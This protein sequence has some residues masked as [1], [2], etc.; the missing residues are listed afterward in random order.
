MK[1]LIILICMF[2]ANTSYAQVNRMRVDVTTEMLQDG[3]IDSDRYF[4]FNFNY[5]ELESQNFETLCDVISVTVNNKNCSNPEMSGNKAL[6]LKPEY[7][8]ANYNGAENFICKYRKISSENAELVITIKSFDYQII[9]RII[10]NIKSNSLVDYK[11]Q[12]S[13][14]SSITNKLE[15]VEYK[16]IKAKSSF[17]AGWE[18]V[19]LGCN[20]LAIPVLPKK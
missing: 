5:L 1:I 4:I 3:K 6:W 16:P 12:M 20:K 18:T 10:A 14:T 17:S 2:I 8:N 9:H 11:G 7:A 13:K 15:A 19:E